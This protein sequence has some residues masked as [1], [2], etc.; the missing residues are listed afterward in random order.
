MFRIAA[1]V[2]AAAF[3]ADEIAALL[4]EEDTD[5]E[6]TLEHLV[7][8]HLLNDDGDG[9]YRYHDLIRDYAVECL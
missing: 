8:V 9:R 6:A 2:P 1:L 5:V 4:G 7:D 3:D